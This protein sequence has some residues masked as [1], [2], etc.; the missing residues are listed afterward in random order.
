MT[1]ANNVTDGE[2][3]IFDDIKRHVA[4]LY[5]SLAQMN[6]SCAVSAA[7]PTTCRMTFQ[8]ILRTSKYQYQTFKKH[9]KQTTHE[10][11]STIL[12]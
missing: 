5:R 11:I 4:F 1:K 10:D 8:M 7:S 9:F 3:K 6:A 2:H 12:K